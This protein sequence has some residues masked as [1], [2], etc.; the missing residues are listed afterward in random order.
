MT[1]KETGHSNPVAPFHGKDCDSDLVRGQCGAA[2]F[3]GCAYPKAES[4][5]RCVGPIKWIEHAAAASS[6]PYI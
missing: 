1:P 2:G 6:P 4:H 5:A 3:S